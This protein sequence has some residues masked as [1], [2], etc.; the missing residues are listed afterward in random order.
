VAGERRCPL[1]FAPLRRFLKDVVSFF[2]AESH[3]KLVSGTEV[4][5]LLVFVHAILRKFLLKS[6]LSQRATSVDV[7]LL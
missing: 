3:T 6:T 2:S 1:D 4:C 5:D 7:A